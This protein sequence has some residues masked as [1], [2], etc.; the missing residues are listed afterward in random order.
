MSKNH[1]I[2]SKIPK[3]NQGIITEFIYMNTL[4]SYRK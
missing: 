2:Q 3:Q 1:T 4:K